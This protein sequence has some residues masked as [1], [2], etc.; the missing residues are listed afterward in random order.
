MV[1]LGMGQLFVIFTF[2]NQILENT[3]SANTK[4][5]ISIMIIHININYVKGSV[6]C[7][8]Y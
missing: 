1:Y 4:K 6:L 2:G 3:K 7:F 8:S 5:M